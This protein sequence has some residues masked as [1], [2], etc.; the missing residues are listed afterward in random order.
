[1]V[2]AVLL[3]VQRGTYAPGASEPPRRWFS[4]RQIGKWRIP[5]PLDLPYNKSES[6]RQELL[7]PR[8][9]RL[10]AAS[11]GLAAKQLADVKL[12]AE[13]GSGVGQ[14]LSSWQVHCRL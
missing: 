14:S 9:V 5:R 12:A 4:W 6:I 2:A 7:D 10:M 11:R 1:M 3:T 13:P 8:L